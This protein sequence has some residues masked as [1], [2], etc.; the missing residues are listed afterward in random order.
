MK[1]LIPSILVC[2]AALMGCRDPHA[3]HSHDGDDHDHAHAHSHAHDAPH[4]GTGVELG[5][6][7][8]HLE[9]VREQEPGKLK[10][11]VLDGHMENFVRVPAETFQIRAKVGEEQRLLE[12]KAVGNEATGE[13]VGNTSYF[14]VE[15]DW[16]KEYGEFECELVDLSIKGISFKS[17]PFRFPGG[18]E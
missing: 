11:W 1:T 18:N 12:L 10:V 8:F 13:T 14:E 6:H 2:I 3:G 5:E 16:L 9:L 4:G 7:Q 17:V 15:A